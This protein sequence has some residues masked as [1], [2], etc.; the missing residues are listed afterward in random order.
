MRRAILSLLL[1]TAAGVP[2][3]AQAPADT[4]TIRAQLH[5]IAD[6]WNA[7]NMAGHVAIYADSATMMGGRGLIWGRDA[8]RAGLERN[9]WKDGQPL[10]QLRFEEIEIRLLGRG[11][12]VA[13]VTGRFILAGGGRAEASGRFSTIWEWKNGRWLTVHDHSS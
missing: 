5:A 12:D 3:Y 8:I 10:Q 4:A 9:F 1:F 13:V 6:A 7:G 2:G 11:R